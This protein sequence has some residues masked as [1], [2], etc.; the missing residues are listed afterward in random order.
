MNAGVYKTSEDTQHLCKCTTLDV[1]KDS[2]IGDITCPTGQFVTTYYPLLNK[3][4]CCSACGVTDVKYSVPDGCEPSTNFLSD[5]SMFY[6][7]PHFSN[8]IPM[9][10]QLRTKCS[11]VIDPNEVCDESAMSS[12]KDKCILYDIDTSKCNDNTIKNVEQNCMTHEL[13]YFDTAKVL[14]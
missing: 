5:L 12:V 7:N 11:N 9:G 1:P 2:Q 14:M 3:V 8:N 13:K 6:D 4:D 10:N